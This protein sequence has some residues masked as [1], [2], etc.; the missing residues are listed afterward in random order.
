MVLVFVECG[1]DHTV[2]YGGFV[3]PN[4]GG[5]VTKFAP[6]AALNSIS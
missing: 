2:E 6:D 3:P 5:K 4:L 1:K